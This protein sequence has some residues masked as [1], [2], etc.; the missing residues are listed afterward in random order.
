MNASA[1]V[2]CS[3][4]VEC[5]SATILTR[6]RAY[7]HSLSLSLS[8]SPPSIACV[9][10]PRQ[11]QLWFDT[12][13]LMIAEPGADV[14]ELDLIRFQPL[15]AVVKADG[16][17]KARIVIDLARNFNDP[18]AKQPFRY[19]SVDDAVNLSSPNCWYGKLDLSN[20]FLSF[21]LH[22]DVVP[23]FT[24]RFDGQLYQFTRMPFGLTTAPLV[25]TQLLSV[26]AFAIRR[27]I[28]R[29]VR[30]L[31]DFLF[32]ADSREALSR[33]LTAAQQ[34]FADF[35]LVV[36][37]SKTEGPVQSITFLGIE[38]NS[39]EQTLAC[40]ADRIAELRALIRVTQPLRVV[41]RRHLE[42]LIGKLSFA[43][44]VLPG[45]RPFMR[46]LLDSLR[47]GR[48]RHRGAAV[49]TD[50][51][52][53]ADLRYWL[54]H[55]DQW[56]GKHR[57]RT[58]RSAPIV[59]AS[60]A[61]L[62]GFGFYLE[63]VLTHVDSSSWPPALLRG[64]GYSGVYSPEHAALHSSHTNM[65]GVSC[66]RSTRPLGLMRTSCATS[67]WSSSWTVR[68]MSTSSTGKRHEARCSLLCCASCTIW[69][70]SSTTSTSLQRID[71][72]STTSLLT[73]CRDHHVCP[74]LRASIQHTECLHHAGAQ[75]SDDRRSPQY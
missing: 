32:L 8:H 62:D 27:A 65:H 11:R 7:A 3:T 40:T 74:G 19:A 31:D 20:C 54:N 71:Q 52:F 75:S 43:A 41:R 37:P 28:K 35:G 56:N 58:S 60:D 73:S 70:I 9:N 25:C 14:T 42:S 49:K 22:P 36:N 64:V 15:L 68:P 47:R 13:D 29:F 72:G 12:I 45:A 10:G 48:R 4:C 39:I 67:Q 33:A 59:F 18:I 1:G 50:P 16:S 34:I 6:S 55:L 53:H 24:F 38:I 21:P 17:R 23:Y 57:W 51:G 26:V 44:Q 66:S 30:Y 5:G 46:R 69:Q 63:S 2:G 61:S